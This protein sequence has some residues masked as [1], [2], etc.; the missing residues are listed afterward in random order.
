[1][2]LFRD[3]Q[4]CLNHGSNFAEFFTMKPL[5]SKIFGYATACDQ[6]SAI[7]IWAWNLRSVP[8]V[9]HIILKGAKVPILIPIDVT[10]LSEC[11][12]S[13]SFMEGL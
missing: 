9:A 10:F 4:D 6:P 7:E 2:V 1:M 11:S 13:P 5:P 8:R 3:F 12:L